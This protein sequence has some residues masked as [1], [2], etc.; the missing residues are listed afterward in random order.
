MIA[1]LWVLVCL[2][3]LILN[4]WFGREG[5]SWQSHSIENTG[6]AAVAVGIADIQGGFN[7]TGAEHQSVAF[8]FP[9]SRVKSAVG[10]RNLKL[11][12]NI[13]IYHQT[14]VSVGKS[15]VQFRTFYFALVGQGTGIWQVH[16]IIVG[17]SPEG[18]AFPNFLF[19]SG[20]NGV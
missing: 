2:V 11:I 7:G 15:Q 18:Q 8:L 14:T 10:T 6:L 16:L 1:A 13:F 20:V 3:G 9:L 19:A 17:Q 5:R 12:G 4:L